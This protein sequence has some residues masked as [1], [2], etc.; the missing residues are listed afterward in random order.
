M[1][2]AAVP[3][4]GDH[5]GEKRALRMPA[6]MDPSEKPLTGRK[7]RKM[8]LIVGIV[9]AAALAVLLFV[10]L[11]AKASIS[12]PS[13]GEPAPDFSLTTSTGLGHVGTPA[14]GGSDGRPIVLLFFGNWC[15]L[16]HGELRSLAAQ[17]R[18]QRSD[19]DLRHLAVIGVDSLDSPSSVRSFAASSG[20][21]FPV[22]DD[23]SAYVTTAVYGFTGDPYAVFISGTGTITTIHRGLLGVSQFVSLEQK[24]VR[25]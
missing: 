11:D 4:T 14:S 13:V 1:T 16:C 20:V 12:F 19:P 6:A 7:P 3:P 10:G 24:L 18:R 22:G 15:P 8:F 25:Q 9:L 23:T 2:D 17:V 5:S 21:T